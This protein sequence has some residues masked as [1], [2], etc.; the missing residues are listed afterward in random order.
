MRSLHTVRIS[1]LSESVYAVETTCR[2]PFLRSLALRLPDHARTWKAI[3][4]A[5]TLRELELSL[6][7]NVDVAPMELE[8]V[9]PL[10]NL[11]RLTLADASMHSCGPLLERLGLME[12]RTLRFIDTVESSSSASME[13]LIAAL[14]LMPQ[15]TEVQ[16]CSRG[17][18]Q[19]LL[20]ALQHSP[21]PPAVRIVVRE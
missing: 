11:H 16:L 9:Q 13:P 5:P 18:A 3:A 7:W 19:N 2:L 4:A 10:S 15:L 8:R 1:R 21:L 12:L 17:S 14:R 6:F 20:D